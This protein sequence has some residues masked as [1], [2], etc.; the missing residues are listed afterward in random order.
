ALKTRMD[1]TPP[2]HIPK[3]IFDI[4]ITGLIRNAI[5]YTPDGGKIDIFVTKTN[6]HP[7]LVITDYG[8]GFTREKLHLIFENYFTPPDSS[9]YT[10]K[11]HYA[12]NA[13]GRGFDLLRI[14]LFS[15]RYHF[16]LDID[17]TR[18]RFIPSDTD[19][20]PG[21][22]RHCTFCTVPDDCYNSGGTTLRLVFSDNK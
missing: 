19:T 16:T 20:C 6:H 12:F 8:I 21:N 18:C 13:G 22:I 10:T 3:E 7:T 4:I 14:K 15:E 2:V 9:E 5:E 17:S 11:T 1:K